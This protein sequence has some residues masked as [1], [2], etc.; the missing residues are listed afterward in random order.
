MLGIVPLD[1]L[2]ALAFVSYFN[3]DAVLFQEPSGVGGAVGADFGN[4]DRG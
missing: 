3:P 1:S 2:L 4:D